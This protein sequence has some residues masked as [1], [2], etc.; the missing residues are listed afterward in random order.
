[1]G[2]FS[3]PLFGAVYDYPPQALKMVL[4]VLAIAGL[5]A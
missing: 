2:L 1:M 3:S 4:S 5:L